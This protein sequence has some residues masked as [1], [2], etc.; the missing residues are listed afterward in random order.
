MYEIY[1]FVQA[2]AE[3]LECF[4]QFHVNPLYIAGYG[5]VQ[6]AYAHLH[7]LKLLV[8]CPASIYNALGQPFQQVLL[9]AF[10]YLLHQFVHLFVVDGAFQFVGL[11]GGVKIG[12]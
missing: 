10:H 7:P 2:P 8:A 9:A 1:R 5:R 12:L 3:I 6:F 11:G 4:F